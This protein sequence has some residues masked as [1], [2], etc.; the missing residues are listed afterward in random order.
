[1]AV[2]PNETTRTPEQQLHDKASR[3][4][5]LSTS[6]QAQLATWY[7]EQDKFERNLLS[8]AGSAPRFTTLQA[9]VQTALTQLQTVTQRIQK[10][11]DQ[12]EAVR[13]EIAALQRQLA[14]TSTS[15]S[16]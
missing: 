10:V 13:R 4:I 16:A 11:T 12:N 6:E 7:A 1:M 15:P 9:Q 3:G 5:A 14:Q 8:S 2:D